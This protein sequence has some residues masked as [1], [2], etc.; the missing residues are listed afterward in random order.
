MADEGDL[1]YLPEQFRESARRNHDAA[2]EADGL[3]RRLGNTTA[4]SGAFGGA[5][6][7]GYTAGFNTDTADRTRRARR[8]QEDRDDIGDG[9]S[10]TADLGEDTDLRAR[11][12]LRTPDRQVSRA[13]ADGM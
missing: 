1:E 11:L 3:A 9:G 7:A 2:D 6:A 8:A 10:T 4:A 5:R 13:V 12:A